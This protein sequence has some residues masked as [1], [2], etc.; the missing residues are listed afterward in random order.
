MKKCNQ[1]HAFYLLLLNILNS[2]SVF[3]IN[4]IIKFDTYLYTNII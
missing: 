1:E 3:L 2:T 4:R